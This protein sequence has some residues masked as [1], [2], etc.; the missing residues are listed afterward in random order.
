MLGRSGNYAA[1]EV[2]AG[3]VVELGTD[4]AQVRSN[5]A[6]ALRGLGRPGQAL[7]EPK[8]GVEAVP[9]TR[10]AQEQCVLVQAAVEGLPSPRRARSCLNLQGEGLSQRYG[11]GT[12]PRGRGWGGPVP[13]GGGHGV[14]AGG[15][16]AC[17]WGLA[18]F[19]PCTRREQA[20]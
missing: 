3:Q 4:D 19:T 17:D 13:R 10:W 20:K 14:D 6:A 15:E 12:R 16:L 5:L 2:D 1:A 7:Q 18:G 8:T 9:Q 11:P